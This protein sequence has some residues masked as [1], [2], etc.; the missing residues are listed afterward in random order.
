MEKILVSLAEAK[1]RLSELSDLAARGEEVVITKRGKPVV[2]LSRVEPARKPVDRERLL[3][4]TAPMPVQ[5]EDA[6]DFIRRLRE[7]ARY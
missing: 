5:S 4:L 3:R 1:A 2:R 6:G 7:E